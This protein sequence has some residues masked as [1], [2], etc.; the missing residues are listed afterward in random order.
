MNLF[1]QTKN[2]LSLIFIFLMISSIFAQGKD[3]KIVMKI[4]NEI[5]TN[6]DIE[7]EYSYLIALN[8][9]LEN[10]DKEKIITFAKQS[11]VKEKI[12]KLEIIKYF[13]LNKKNQMID[14]IIRNIYIGLNI[15]SEKD[16][17]NYLQGYNLKFNDVYKK[18]EIETVWNQI[19]YSKYKN[20]IVI[21]EENLKKKILDNPQ[22]KES[23]LLSELIFDFENKNEINAKYQNILKSIND[24]GFKETVI[25]FSIAD[26]KSNFGSLGWVSINIL[27]EKI[28]KELENLSVGE[29]TKP[30]IV[31]SGMLVLKLDEKKIEDEKVDLNKEL[32]KIIKFETNAQLNNFS[33]IYFN[34][35]KNYLSINEY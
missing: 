11:L 8:K 29:F 13:E 2:Y 6:I 19:I 4:N 31:P 7:N 23:V 10:I 35:V 18:I 26:S 12:K 20:K 30:I 27:S 22:K 28:K 24:I 16:F 21:N 14:G 34:K 9:N 1:K 25:K 3:V 17:K 33:I 32:E 15:N 5:I